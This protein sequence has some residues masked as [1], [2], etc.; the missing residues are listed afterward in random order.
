MPSNYARAKERKITQCNP[1]YPNSPHT[2][3]EPRRARR[4]QQPTH[5][6]AQILKVNRLGDVVVEA[7]L[8]ALVEDVGHDV[9]GEGDD[10]HAR[11]GVGG[12]P[13]ADLAAGL[14]AVFAGHVEVA[15]W[16]RWVS[17][18]VWGVLFCL[19]IGWVG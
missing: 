12:F 19:G 11:V 8:Q 3:T 14:V 9:G 15:L 18:V 7:G 1:L 2:L 5:R 16:R 17:N 13:G 6:L 10:G 4:I